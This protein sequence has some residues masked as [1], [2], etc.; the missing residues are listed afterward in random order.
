M[1]GRVD[2]VEKNVTDL[3]QLVFAIK[4]EQEQCMSS[5]QAVQDQR[6]SRIE[7]V[8]SSMAHE[9]STVQEVDPS[10][11][12]LPSALPLFI[13][14]RPP[15]IVDVVGT[16]TLYPA[17]QPVV[18]NDSSLAIKKVELPNFDGVDP[19]A[20]LARAEQYFSINNTRE[21][22]KVQLALDSSVDAYIDT[23][24]AL[25][26]QIEGSQLKRWNDSGIHWSP[27]R[28]GPK[29]DM[30]HNSSGPSKLS[31]PSIT[32]TPPRPSSTFS[33]NQGTRHYTHQEFLELRAKGLCYKCK[34]PFH[35]MH[36]CPNKSLRALIIGDDEEK[37]PDPDLGLSELDHPQIEVINEA[38]F[39]TMDLPFYSIGGISSP[40][41]LKLQGRIRG[42]D[43]TVLIDSGASHNFILGCWIAPSSYN[44]PKDLEIDDE[45]VEPETL[46]QKIL[47]VV[48]GIQVLQVLVKWKGKPLEDATWMSY[49]DFVNQFP[50][51]NLEDKVVLQ[52]RSTDRSSPLVNHEDLGQ[53]QAPKPLRVYYRKKWERRMSWQEWKVLSMT[54]H[55]SHWEVKQLEGIA[56]EESHGN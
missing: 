13:Q 49:V 45:L 54:C 55:P 51:A 46:L 34:Q 3:Q 10:F 24:V 15:V 52:R 11:I 1:E 22:M 7:S 47:E 33:R 44:L 4:L 26:S 9:K 56:D 36:E 8:I 50:A 42:T 28:F 16:S 53:D 6:S 29:I 31:L 5:F 39:N 37:P 19:V 21:E 12:L 2:S 23:F 14:S 25:V 48:N 20:W 18:V 40:N 17:T 27:P 38:H 35:P 32:T 43:V 30:D 41:T